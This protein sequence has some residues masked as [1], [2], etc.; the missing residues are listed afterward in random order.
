MRIYHEY[1]PEPEKEIK[2]TMEPIHKTEFP[3]QDSI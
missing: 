3:L 2:L 1:F